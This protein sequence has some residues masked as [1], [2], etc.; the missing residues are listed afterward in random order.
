V[1]TG[2]T[3]E[4]LICRCFVVTEGAIRSAI[5][6]HDLRHVE[7]VTAVT[8]AGGGCS[9]CWDEIQGILDA[10]HGKP[11]GRHVPDGTGLSD[12][13]KRARIVQL[14]DGELRPAFAMNGIDVALSDVAGDRVLVRF[15]GDAVGTTSA[16]FL[17]LKRWMV[18]KMTALIGRK[19]NLVEL[20][21]LEGLAK[22][23][24]S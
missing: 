20:N 23:S 19:M 9:S 10:A 7:E 3:D 12:A 22:T 2:A 24:K 16:G 5:R 15:T 11:P 14:L 21:V 17:A 13:Q 8:R 4:K 6:E 1:D 18:D